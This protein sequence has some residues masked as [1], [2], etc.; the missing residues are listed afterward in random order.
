MKGEI[1]EIEGDQRGR[2]GKESGVKEKERWG[3]QKKSLVSFFGSRYSIL[4]APSA[5]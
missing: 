1:E 3:G 5:L 2:K 4:N